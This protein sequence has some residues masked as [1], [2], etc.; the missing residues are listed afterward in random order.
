MHAKVRFEDEWKESV[1]DGTSRI[2]SENKGIH[3]ALMFG[4]V[5]GPERGTAKKERERE[6]IHQ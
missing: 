2:D 5:H 1:V 3:V 6:R 4:I